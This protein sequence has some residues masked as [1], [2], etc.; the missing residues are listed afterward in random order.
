MTL[1]VIMIS[2]SQVRHRCCHPNFPGEVCAE[3]LGSLSRAEVADILQ[4][5]EFDPAILGYCFR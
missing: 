3:L 1:A 5:Q 4:M 2:L